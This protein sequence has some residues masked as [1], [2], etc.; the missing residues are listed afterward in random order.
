ME[1]TTRVITIFRFNVDRRFGFMHQIFADI[2][3]S[4]A[5][6]F[7]RLYYFLM[8]IYRTLYER[9]KLFWIAE[10]LVQENDFFFK[11]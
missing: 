8:F 3:E 5:F 7:P 1:K 6:N 9:I 11:N 4:K 2:S 10:C